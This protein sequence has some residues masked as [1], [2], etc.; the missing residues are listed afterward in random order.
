MIYCDF[1]NEIKMKSKLVQHFSL[2]IALLG[3]LTLTAQNNKLIKEKTQLITHVQLIDGT[4][5]PAVD[6][7]VRIQGNKIIQIG[8]LLP[9]KEEMVID[10][11][12]WVLAPGFIDSHSHHFGDLDNHPEALPTNNQG[13]TTIIIGQDGESYPM[14]TIAQMRSR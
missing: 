8:A 4:G 1:E 13:I 2:L 5:K 7:A 10:G 11:Q 12:G 6:A 14:D 9:Q 3:C